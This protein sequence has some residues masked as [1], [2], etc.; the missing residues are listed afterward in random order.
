MYMCTYNT[1]T[2]YVH[3]AGADEEHTI[4]ELEDFIN[5]FLWNVEIDLMLNHG[6]IK[7]Q[8][9]GMYTYMYALYTCIYST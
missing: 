2:Y 4:V 7:D 3:F 8:V 9:H 6:K 1:C 5:R